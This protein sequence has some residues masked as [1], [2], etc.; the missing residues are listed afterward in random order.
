[1]NT[2]SR[3]INGS[4]VFGIN[5]M[6]DRNYP[7]NEAL[8]SGIHPKL[9]ED[10]SDREYPRNEALMDGIHPKLRD[11]PA[12]EALKTTPPTSRR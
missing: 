7:C 12:F 5:D 6:A 3:S 1:M 4:E 2:E 10:D 11:V 9:F 8:M